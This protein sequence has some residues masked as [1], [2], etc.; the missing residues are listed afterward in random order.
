MVYDDWLVGKVDG[1]LFVV[2][3]WWWLFG[4]NDGWI[5]GLIDADDWLVMIGVID[6]LFFICFCCI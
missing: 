4:L 1:F 3:D 2:D 6:E 5:G